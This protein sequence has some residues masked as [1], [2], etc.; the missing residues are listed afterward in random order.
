M[1]YF[2]KQ[3]YIYIYIYIY[4]YQMYTWFNVSC[5]EGLVYYIKS[6]LICVHVHEAPGRK[7]FFRPQQRD[8]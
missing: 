3:S 2:E 8:T 7:Q 6:T 1:G 4:I 5:S